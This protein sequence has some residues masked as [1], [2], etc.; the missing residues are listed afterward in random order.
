MSIPTDKDVRRSLRIIIADDEADTVLTLRA[1]LIDDGHD[2]IG[3]HSAI[4][5]IRELE[6]QVP[7][8]VIVDINMPSV[9]GYEVA[10]ETKRIYGTEA[11]LLIAISGKWTGQTDRM[12][13]TLAGFDHFLEKPCDIGLLRELLEPLTLQPPK[14]PPPFVDNTVGGT[15]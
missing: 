4:A 8:V 15:K 1:L 2:V 9:S 11:P 5:V 7:D 13:S 10:R 12:L 3:K 14:R 6:R